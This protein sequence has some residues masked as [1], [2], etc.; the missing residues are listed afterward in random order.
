[1]HRKN[2]QPVRFAAMVM[3]LLGILSGGLL[4]AS[5]ASAATTFRVDYRSQFAEAYSD[6]VSPDGC[7]FTSVMAGAGYSPEEGSTMFYS[8]YS[9]N[10]CT[11]EFYYSAYGSAPTDV[12]T[13]DK[14]FVHA[15]ATVL[16]SDGSQI[17]LDLTWQGTGPVMRGGTNSRTILPGQFVNRFS[18][19]GTSQEA[20]VT[21]TPSFA[22]GV[23]SQA[24][25]S[26]LTVMI[27][28][29]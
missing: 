3:A 27:G 13:F 11:Q 24:K 28:N 19:R 29:P 22:S 4:V 21:G 6:M 1:M 25:G 20:V 2:L 9:F 12:F 16:L 18:L 26:S 8:T 23:I 7:T 15:V 14:D 17:Y 5:P 10:D